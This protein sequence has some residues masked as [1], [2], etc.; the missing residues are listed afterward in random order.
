MSRVFEILA[1]AHEM[2]DFDRVPFANRRRRMFGPLDDR[3][4][5]LDGHKLVPEANALEKIDHRAPHK[6]LC[7]S[8]NNN[9][10]ASV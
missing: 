4:I 7:L 9:V 1:A 2:H 3:A 10:H 5:D 6:L 8:I